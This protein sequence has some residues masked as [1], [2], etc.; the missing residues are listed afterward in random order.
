MIK[1]HKVAHDLLFHRR[2]RVIAS[3]SSGGETVDPWSAKTS[4]RLLR[5]CPAQAQAGEL[6]STALDMTTWRRAASAVP[7]V[8]SGVMFLDLGEHMLELDETRCEARQEMVLELMTSGR[9][10]EM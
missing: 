7:V 6:R 3:A 1:S 4:V 8:C 9:M 10:S 2:R 5:I